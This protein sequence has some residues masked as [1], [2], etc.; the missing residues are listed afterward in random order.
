MRERTEVEVSFELNGTPR[1]LRVDA[2]RTLL[3]VLR[4]HLGVLD[5]KEGCSEGVCGACTVLLDDRPVSSCLVLIPRIDGRRVTTLT[6]LAVEGKPHPLQEAFVR[7]GA[8]QCGF[9]TPGMILTACAYVRAHPG[10]TREALRRALAGN[11]CR[12][13]GYV[14]ILDAVEAYARDARHGG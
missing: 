3:S 7:F 9:C 5:V 14:K 8:V 11:L 13:T 6:G 10:V 2:H 12:C 1:H 4:D